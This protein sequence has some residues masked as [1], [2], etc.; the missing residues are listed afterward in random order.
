MYWGFFGF[1]GK[2]GLPWAFLFYYQYWG[3]LGFQGEKLGLLCML[4]KS[5]VGQKLTKQ[6]QKPQKRKALTMKPSQK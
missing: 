1:Q 6:R 4:P 5:W 3:F 2:W